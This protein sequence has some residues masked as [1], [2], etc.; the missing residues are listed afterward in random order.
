MKH[1]VL[2]AIAGLAMAVGLSAP[3]AGAS[4]GHRHRVPP[5][6]AMLLK[7]KQMPAGWRVTRVGGASPATSGCLAPKGMPKAV[8]RASR[9]FAHRGSVPELVEKLA[10]FRALPATKFTALLRTLSGC[11]AFSFRDNGKKVR[12][13]VAKV[14]FPH[15]GDQSAAYEFSFPVKG[16]TVGIDA[17][18]ARKGHI[19]LLLMEADFGSPSV[20]QFEHVAKLAVAKVH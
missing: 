13:K 20:V 1:R 9:A 14:S 18:I 6:P 16:L 11:R 5:L 4:P 10:A 15:L 12:A 8:A 3:V 17:L 7:A 19:A 2:A